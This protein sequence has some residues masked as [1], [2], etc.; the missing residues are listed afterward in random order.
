MTVISTEINAQKNLFHDF[1]IC[2]ELNKVCL[3]QICTTNQNVQSVDGIL[4]ANTE[5]GF[6]F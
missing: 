6:A 3:L 2:D 5:S 4:H 1:T